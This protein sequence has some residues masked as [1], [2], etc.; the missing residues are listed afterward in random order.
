M[1]EKRRVTI[2]EE[3]IL[4]DAFK[5]IKDLNDEIDYTN[6]SSMTISDIYYLSCETEI[7]YHKIFSYFMSKYVLKNLDDK[8][9]R[10]LKREG[11]EKWN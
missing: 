10:Y 7:S 5:K 6:F 2:E 1:N 4:L 11:K 9:I 3:N 8:K